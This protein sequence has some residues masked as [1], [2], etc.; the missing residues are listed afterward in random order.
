MSIRAE[1]LVKRYGGRKVVNGASLEAKRGDIVGLL[2]PNGAGK[3]TTFYLITGLIKP[4]D[5]EIFLDEQSITHQPVFQRARLGLH[6]L[7]QEASVFR[8]LTV[9]QNLDLILERSK[10]SRSERAVRRSD[11]IERFNLGYLQQQRADTLS[12]GERR[13]LEIARALACEP[14]FLLLDE[15]FSGV[16]PISVEELQNI[17]IEL[18]SEGL[19][20]VITDHNV[21]ETLKVTDYAYLINNGKVF[22]SGTPEE[23]V[24]D[25]EA[26]KYY[27]GERFRLE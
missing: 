1:G 3:T 2:G 13:R 26:R 11:L 22:L 19:G 23:I 24:A 20:I 9:Q 12:S 7:P 4:Q 14:E 8:K 16:D 27:L 18:K 17:I 15:P 6:Y 5:G 21:R 25:P 10:L